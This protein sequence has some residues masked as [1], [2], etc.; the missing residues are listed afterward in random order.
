[1]VIDE[2]EPSKWNFE[3]I[4]NIK[5]WM[6]KIVRIQESMKQL[7]SKGKYRHSNSY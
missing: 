2:L 6:A 7:L 5:P 4:E 3:G 1:M